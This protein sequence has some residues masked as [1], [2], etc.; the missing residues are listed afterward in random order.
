MMAKKS[1]INK[2]PARWDFIQASSGLVLAI[3]MWMHMF[4]V[5]SI[6]LGKDAMYFVSRMFEGEPIF[7]KPYPILV[8]G[9]AIV[10][11]TIVIIH[12]FVAMRKIPSSYKEYKALNQHAVS[13]NHSDTWLWYVQVIT[14]FVL[15]FLVSVHLYHIIVH[16]SDIGPYASADLAWTGNMWPLYLI[17]LFAVEFHG[18]IGLYRLAVKWGFLLGKDP[19]KQ[20]ARLKKIMWF[21]IVFFITLGLTT[22]SAYV[23]IGIA[24]QDKAGERYIP[25]YK[26]KSAQPSPLEH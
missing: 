2:W 11:F 4:M 3:F 17:M 8:S 7:G 16:P 21:L 24:H 19:K 13:F 12:A 14:G 15:F 23:K 6:L 10:I 9:F 26:I 22:L 25:T 18:C 1:Q 20:R 5:S